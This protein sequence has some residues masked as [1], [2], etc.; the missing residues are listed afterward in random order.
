MMRKMISIL[1]RNQPGVLSHVAGLVTRRGYNV[2]S[3][4]AGP[5][6]EPAITRIT[7]VVAGDEP[8]LEQVTKQIRKLIDVIKVQDLKYSESIVRELFLMTVFVPVNRRQE[9]MSAANTFGAKVVDIAEKTMTL[10][11]VGN[12]IQ[13]NAM[14]KAVEDFKVKYI[15]RTGTVALPLE[16]QMDKNGALM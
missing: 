6:E 12:M 14:M 5:T 15:A 11:F 1:V 13:V 9:L 8:V 2:E 16:S 10:E 4:A 3:I 7:L